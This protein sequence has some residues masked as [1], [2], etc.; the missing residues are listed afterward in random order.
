LYYITLKEIKNKMKELNKLI[1]IIKKLRDPVKGCPW[2][3]K[4]TVDSL[5]EYVLEEA[6]ELVESIEMQLPE[7]Q[8]EELGDLLLQIMLLS[9]I[10][11]EKEN[12]SIKDVIITLIN[13]LVNRHPHV[14]GNASVESAEEV[15]QNWEKIK[16]KEKNNTSIISDYPSHMPALL[17]A[18]RISEQASSVGFDWKNPREALIKVQEEL[19]ELKVEIQAER[20]DK[21]TEEIGDILFAIA[22]VSRLSGVNPESALKKSNKKFISRFRFIEKQLLKQNK[23][24]NQVSLQEMEILWQ[25]S[26]K[27]KSIP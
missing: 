14:F 21:I 27:V 17:T 19:R 15:K 26:K 12:F 18:K 10:N 7:K 6:H 9:Q 5:K 20:E 4:Q 22:N 8:K 23:E 1:N 13:K 3:R 25:K 16:R 24:I 11:Q 2:D